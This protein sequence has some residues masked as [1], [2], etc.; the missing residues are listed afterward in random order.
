[1][2]FGNQSAVP[3]T[4]SAL[5]NVTLNNVSTATMTINKIYFA[6]ANPGDFAMVGNTCGATL[7]AGAN[8]TV[9]VTFSPTA[10]GARSANLSFMDDA[11][12]T[13]FQTVPLTGTG[14]DSSA[15]SAPGL[16]NQA[17]VNGAVVSTTGIPVTVSWTASITGV[18]DHYEL[19][20]SINNG[21]FTSVALPTPTS[22][23]V[24]L[25]VAL[26]TSNNFRV[27][28]CNATNNCSAYSTGT[29]RALAAVQETVK[30]ISY[31]GA[32]TNQ[33]VAGSFGGSVRFASTNRDKAQYK[34][35]AT[36]VSFASTVGP[37]R[38]RISVS[39]DGGA[40]Q[41]IDLYAPVQQTGKV[42]FSVSGL[43][44]GRSHQIVVQVLGNRNPLST[45]NRADVDGFITM[46]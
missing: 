41:T 35:T 14:T 8:C 17:I 46:R 24:V 34:F 26:G 16:P 32:W 9:S 38:G 21:A 31:S 20:R 25:N 12:N 29:T 18:V 44:A 36:S 30:D 11:A 33:V 37:N 45:A 40:A 5:R 23:S 27:R 42:V 4:T 2:N 43:A 19:E 22:T 6:G 28:A 3:A 7:A 39:I 13:S 1:V 10:L 15:P